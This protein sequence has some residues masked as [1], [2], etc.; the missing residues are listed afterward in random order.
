MF[1]EGADGSFVAYGVIDVCRT[2]RDTVLTFN[3][4]WDPNF[5]HA[6]SEMYFLLSSEDLVAAQATAPQL[7]LAG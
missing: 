6:Y 5:I 2:G 3:T 4:W 7:R 1:L